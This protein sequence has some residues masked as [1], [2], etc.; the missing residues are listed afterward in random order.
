MLKM[1][2]KSIHNIIKYYKINKL[3]LIHTIIVGIKKILAHVINQK[4]ICHTTQVIYSIYLSQKVNIHS[5]FVFAF[6][7]VN[8]LFDYIW[9]NKVDYYISWIRLY[10]LILIYDKLEFNLRP[11]FDISKYYYKTL[12]YINHSLSNQ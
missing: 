7:I 5:I 10:K 9:L 4:K 1:V 12:R 3:I 2:V 8:I 6:F 11:T